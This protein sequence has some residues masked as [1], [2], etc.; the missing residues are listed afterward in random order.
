[1][2][3]AYWLVSAD[4]S[5]PEGYKLYLSA[6]GKAFRRF[7]ARFIVRGGASQLVEGEMR[8]RSVVLEFKDYA[9]ALACY[10]SPEY[11]L[12]RDARKDCATFD[13]VIAEGYEG[14]QPTD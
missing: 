10:Q 11:A 4:I 2:A 8:P 5:D 14:P 12:A 1:M 3:K 7:G 6:S 13:V 9:T